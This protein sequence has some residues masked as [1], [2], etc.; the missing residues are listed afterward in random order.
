[1]KNFVRDAGIHIS[2][3][4]MDKDNN[5]VQPTGANVTLSYVPLNQSTSFTDGNRTFLTFPLTKN[6][7]AG[8]NDWI[9]DWDS[10]VSEPFVVFG[11][12]VTTTVGMPIAAVDFAFRLVANKS[13]RELA[14]D[15][16]WT[17]YQR[18]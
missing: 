5:I 6:P 2:I 10:T 18:G 12:A 14:G 9:L 16:L 17:D 1:M 8:S 4:F 11:H 7:V 15:D 13:N 3:T